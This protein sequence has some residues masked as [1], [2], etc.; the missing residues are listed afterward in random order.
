MRK[1]LSPRA[2]GQDV[3]CGAV[4]TCVS[5]VRGFCLGRSHQ[6]GGKAKPCVDLC[7]DQACPGES[8]TGGGHCL[9]YCDCHSKISERLWRMAIVE[10]SLY[11]HSFHILQQAESEKANQPLRGRQA[12]QG[13]CSCHGRGPSSLSGCNLKRRRWQDVERGQRCSE[14]CCRYRMAV[15]AMFWHLLLNG[16]L[17]RISLGRHSPL[18]CGFDCHPNRPWV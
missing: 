13:F 1:G 12:N 7:G 5:L 3:A 18:L 14:Q 4:G 6:R 15:K 2:R 17:R 10:K 11:G 9:G 8:G 16:S